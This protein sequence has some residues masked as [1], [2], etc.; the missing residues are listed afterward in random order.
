GVGQIDQKAAIEHVRDYI[1]AHG[2]IGG[3]QMKIVWYVADQ[4]N[5][6]SADQVAQEECTTW[7]QQSHVFAALAGGYDTLDACLSKAGVVEV[8]GG[9]TV[10][11]TST[12][13]KYPYLVEL[14]AAAVDR[15]AQFY[16][17]QLAATDY[18]KR[19]RSDAIGQ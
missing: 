17:D 6:K 7:T 10:S 3:R 9:I 1:N 2:G 14:D 11:D 8:T 13:R 15:L 5:G 16:V 19:D 4:L 18:Y 12:Y